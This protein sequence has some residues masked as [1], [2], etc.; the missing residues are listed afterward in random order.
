ML[1]PRPV[2]L[3]DESL[4]VMNFLNEIVMRYPDAISFAPGRPAD[5]FCDVAGCQEALSRYVASVE[6]TDQLAPVHIRQKLG[7]YSKTN[8]IINQLVCVSWRVTRISRLSQRR[9]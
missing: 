7:Q 6:A 8:G 1:I 2:K 3:R 5:Q 9:S 4:D